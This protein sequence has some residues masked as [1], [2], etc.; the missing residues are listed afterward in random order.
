MAIGYI[1]LIEA[2]VGHGYGNG[3][4]FE[5]L[6]RWMKKQYLNLAINVENST[7]RDGLN[8]ECIIKANIQ[9]IF[10]FGALFARIP[11]SI[12]GIKNSH[13]TNTLTTLN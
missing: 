4:P 1:I 13:G 8:I 10:V 5:V 2:G 7:P 11:F 6:N 3:Y 12:A 9:A